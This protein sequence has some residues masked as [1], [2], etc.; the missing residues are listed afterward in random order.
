MALKKSA[1]NSTVIYD[2][3]SNAQT[4]FNIN[5]DLYSGS[6]ILIVDGV[7]SISDSLY[8]TVDENNLPTNEFSIALK[9]PYDID[10]PIIMVQLE[11]TISRLWAQ[12]W[13][14]MRACK[15]L[16]NHLKLEAMKVP[17]ALLVVLAMIILMA[18]RMLAK[19]HQVRL[20]GDGTNRDVDDNGELVI[21]RLYYID[22]ANGFNA[23][24][25]TG[26]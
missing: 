25:E 6:E 12:F 19:F 20:L 13:R 26:E 3:S 10:D 24:F 11:V 9:S 15:I 2:E 5:T 23:N 4:I 8:S 21:D 18:G 17:I 22:A 1:L 14:M 16:H 7:W